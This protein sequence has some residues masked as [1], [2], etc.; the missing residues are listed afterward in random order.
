MKKRLNIILLILIPILLQC[1]YFNTFYNAKRYYRM[2][3][4]ETQKNVTDKV[5][6]QERSNY[7][8]TIEK[9]AKI[10][11]FYPKSRYMDDA[12][13]LMGKAY[14]Y[15]QEY[16]KASRKFEELATNFP[17]SE[18]AI[19]ASLWRARA[20]LEMQEYELA[21]EIMTSMANKKIPS[22]LKGDAYY[23][24]G[25]FHQK[26]DSYD[27]AIEAFQFSS[28]TA[29]KDIRMKALL[30]LGQTFDTTGVYIEAAKA[31]RNILKYNPVEEVE[32][33]SRYQYGRMLRKAGDPQKA[34][35]VFEKLLREE[36]A[37]SAGNASNK[38][39]SHISNIRLEIAACLVNQGQIEDAIVTYQDIIEGYKKKPAASKAL[40]ELGKIYEYYYG[41]YFRA[42]D[43]YKQAQ[44]ENKSSVWADSAEIMHR[45]IERLDALQR[46]I[47]MSEGKTKK[48]SVTAGEEEIEEDT[49]TAQ[50]I[51]DMMQKSMS[52]DENDKR[53]METMAFIASKHFADSVKLLIDDFEYQRMKREDQ[54]P[55]SH[56]G[57]GVNWLLWY[58]SD[59]MP[60]FS[61][62]EFVEEELAIQ[63]E[64]YREFDMAENAELS[65]FKVEE[66]DK[67]LFF[68][69]E[70]YWFRF[71][72]PDS[73]QIQYKKLIHEFPQSKYTPQAIYNL[74]YL[75]S[76]DKNAE[77]DTSFQFLI[78]R[79]PQS[80]YA[81]EARKLLELPLEKTLQDS[82]LDM[83][84]V[85]EEN[86]IKGNAVESAIDQ[87]SKIYKQYPETEYAAKALYSIGWIYDHKLHDSKTAMML[88][89][90]LLTTFPESVYA[91]TISTK[92]NRTKSEIEKAKQDSIRAAQSDSTSQMIP[93]DSSGV[94][95]FADSLQQSIPVDSMQTNIETVPV[96]VPE[97]TSKTE[98]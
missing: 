85:A 95:M 93:A 41:D 51:F 39:M 76:M 90:S 30:A 26:R 46:V 67:N 98:P 96:A 43:N 65:S 77:N 69:A 6:S 20:L 5:S 62:V 49:L 32:Y 75:Q 33:I 68:L 56:E 16:V 54:L 23:Y 19:E 3:Y 47:L 94:M 8:K 48:G 42:A 11:E 38:S 61:Q 87:Y 1:A 12:L 13:L 57:E 35:P 72:L 82:I 92:M 53:Q 70:L 55:E 84:Y 21:E 4:L 64:R 52:S 24:F 7:Q 88:Y 45:D 74:G 10:I 60:S 44:E 31:Y 25:V 2:G 66:K 58:D 36:L 81:N 80:S 22:E 37:L 17:K 9:C 59:I 97:D 83:F 40:Y 50:I 29:S 18:Y 34:M 86:L 28:K 14:F 79:Y 27:E 89:D 78:Q 15:M 73:A 71:D 91:G 63:R